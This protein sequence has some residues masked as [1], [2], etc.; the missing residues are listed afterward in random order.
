M[1]ASHNQ[2]LV[3]SS[4]MNNKQ[5]AEQ[6][7]ARAQQEVT[8]RRAAERERQWRG[9]WRWLLP[10][11]VLTVFLAFLAAPLPLPRKLLVAMGGVC[12]LR[13]AH[14][15][16]AGEVQLPM[17]ARMVGIYAGFSLT[18]I[19][20]LVFRRLGARALGNRPTLALLALFFA[21]MA[22]DGINSTLTELRMPHLYESTN[23]TRL[24]TGLLSG[25]A[26]AP[27]LV[28]LLGVMATPRTSGPMRA[29]VRSPWELLLSITVCASFGA[30]V[31]SEQ[32]AF[33][34]PIALLSVGGVVVVLTI[35]AL[36]I[37]LRMSG[38]DG[39]VTRVRQLG[40]PGALALLV[41]F[42]VLG[43]TAAIRWSAAGI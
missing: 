1:E 17:E 22:F 31:M 24:V 41:A 14:S 16:F 8:T 7:V 32:A 15:Y 30:L 38:L 3:Y 34:Y 35:V 10:G 36:L 20:L 29:V 11:L 23:V 40:T 26:I 6:I 25:I 37:V 28:W 42:T 33:Y 19:V 43:A 18:L 9:P 27:F 2:S 12:G 5:T 39:R 4:T 21:S 13:P